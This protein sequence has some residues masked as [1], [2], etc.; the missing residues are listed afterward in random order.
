MEL[1]FYKHFKERMSADATAIQKPYTTHTISSASA[2]A[3]G[4]DATELIDCNYEEGESK[5]QIQVYKWVLCKFRV[6]RDV[7]ED[8]RSDGTFY[9]NIPTIKDAKGIA[10][11]F[12]K[13]E[14]ELFF[15]LAA[16]NSLNIQDLESREITNDSLKRYLHLSNFLDYELLLNILCSYAASLIK[17]G[18]FLIN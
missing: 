12:T 1:L 10:I 9:A 13:A 2:R 8:V 15:E 4:D 16:M 14:L 11:S 7:N 17:E 5:V 18:R 3:I 6:F